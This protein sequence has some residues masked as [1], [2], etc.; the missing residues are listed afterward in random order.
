MARTVATSLFK[1]VWSKFRNN[2]GLRSFRSAVKGTAKVGTETRLPFSVAKPQFK[3]KNLLPE[4][5][6][7]ENKAGIQLGAPKKPTTF[8]PRAKVVNTQSRA[9]QLGLPPGTQNRLQPEQMNVIPRGSSIESTG[10][11]PLVGSYTPPVRPEV[12]TKISPLQKKSK[13]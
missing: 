12:P 4:G 7:F 2:A 9:K 13:V 5:K 3:S 11:K 1:S 6:G 10:K 8:E